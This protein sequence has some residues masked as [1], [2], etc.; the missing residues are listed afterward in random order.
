MNSAVLTGAIREF[1]TA[2]QI[3]RAAGCAEA[4]AARYARGDTM[5]DPI[6][7]A[8]LMGRSRDVASA[9]LSMAGLDEMSLDLEEAR[10]TSELRRI[11]AKRAGNLNEK[12]ASVDGTPTRACVAGTKPM[13]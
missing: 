8:R 1:G 11:R 4:T 6:R 12:T 5:P 13:G 7:L 9:M 2:K 3:A 10:L